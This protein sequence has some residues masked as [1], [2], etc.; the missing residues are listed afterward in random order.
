M[1][2]ACKLQI[3]C[4]DNLSLYCKGWRAQVAEA[5]VRRDRLSHELA[6]CQ[7]TH[8]CPACFVQ[9]ASLRNILAYDTVS[10]V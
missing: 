1:P 3:N 4:K 7:E 6:V 8:S 9:A 2:H 10:A 5:L